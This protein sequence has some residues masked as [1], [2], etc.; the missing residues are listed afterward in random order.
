MTWFETLAGWIE[1]RDGRRLIYRANAN[2]A[3]QLY[4]ERFY[5]VKAPLIEIMIHRFHLSDVAVFHDHPWASWN[6]ILKGGYVEHTLQDG[7]EAAQFRKPG[8]FG[9]RSAKAKHWVELPEGSAGNVWTLFVTFRREKSWG[10]FTDHGYY[11]FEEYFRMTGVDV[12]NQRPEE[13][14]GWLFPTRIPDV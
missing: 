3:P 11:P 14:R 6:V 1:R 8:Y 7:N 12:V 13:Y 4:L 2:T 9:Q 10:Y 5:I